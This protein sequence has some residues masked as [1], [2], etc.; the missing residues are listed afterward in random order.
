M[1][2]LKT[3]I[4]RDWRGLAFLTYS[5]GSQ[6]GSPIDVALERNSPVGLSGSLT[7]LNATQARWTENWNCGGAG[8]VY[9]T[10]TDS[11]GGSAT[12]TITVID[13]GNC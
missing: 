5:F 7:V 4:D 6:A 12:A 10:V 8:T 13:V 1:L 3:D 2:T 11:A 9:V